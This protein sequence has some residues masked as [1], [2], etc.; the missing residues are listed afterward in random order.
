M[1][2]CPNCGRTILTEK[3]YQSELWAML[4]DL[5][6]QSDHSF[7]Y[8]KCSPEEQGAEPEYWKGNSTTKEEVLDMGELAY[9]TWLTHWLPSMGDCRRYDY[10]YK[11][12]DDNRVICDCGDYI[13]VTEEIVERYDFAHLVKNSLQPSMKTQIEDGYIE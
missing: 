9:K 7:E 11:V 12:T 10:G 8:C 13:D 3:N 5:G 2:K 4:H 6:A 1:R